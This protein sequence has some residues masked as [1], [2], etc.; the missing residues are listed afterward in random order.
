MPLLICEQPR[1]ARYALGVPRVVGREPEL[2]A[3]DAFL[4]GP[5]RTLAIVC[6]VGC[7]GYTAPVNPWEMRFCKTS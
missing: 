1:T 3:V 4:D 5:A 7:T 6:A 2:R